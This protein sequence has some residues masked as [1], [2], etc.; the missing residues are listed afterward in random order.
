MHH[1]IVSLFFLTIGI[2]IFCTSSHA[3]EPTPAAFEISASEVKTIQSKILDR[4]YDL[5]VKLP[6]GY[7]VEKN[8]EKLYPVI[9]FNDAGYNWLTA[10]GVTRAPF[11]LGGYEPAIL[12]GFSYAKGE[13]GTASRVRDYTPTENPDWRRFKTGGGPQYLE[14]IKSEAIPFVE[15]EYRIDSNRRMLVGHSLGGLFR[16]LCLAERTKTFFCLHPL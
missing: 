6:P 1:L 2:L 9:Y 12:I 13:R 4:Q 14:F 5:Y 10:V 3:E 7:D 15:S 8:A 16:R 11:S